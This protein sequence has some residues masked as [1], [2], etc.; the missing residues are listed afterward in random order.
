[1]PPCPAKIISNCAIADDP[2]GLTH[3]FDQEI[4]LA[5]GRGCRKCRPES[6]ELF[7]QVNENGS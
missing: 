5:S 3:I 4:R 1:M 7:E 2:P 6:V